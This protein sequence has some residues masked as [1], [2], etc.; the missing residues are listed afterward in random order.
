MAPTNQSGFDILN[1]G[2]ELQLTSG[3]GDNVVEENEEGDAHID[4]V[5]SD[6][7]EGGLGR[8]VVKLAT[9]EAGRAV[10]FC[11]IVFYNNTCT[12]TDLS[13]MCSCL[14]IAHYY[15]VSW[16]SKP[17]DE[18]LIL[19]VTKMSTREEKVIFFNKRGT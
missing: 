1:S 13:T 14:T 10:D 11:T 7:C 16:K 3:S 15:S 19:K 18:S 6:S 17:S 2:V 9:Q 12:V 4:F 8:A 5:L